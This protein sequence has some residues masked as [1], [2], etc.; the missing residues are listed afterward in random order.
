MCI[1]IIFGQPPLFSLLK[2][3]PRI[4]N[5]QQ[6]RQITRLPNLPNQ[7]KS[8]HTCLNSINMTK[9]N[10]NQPTINN[11][12]QNQQNISEFPSNDS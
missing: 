4:K 10:R 8:K 9:T 1:S 2:M 6:S 12:P 7:Q 3:G 11:N 5:Q